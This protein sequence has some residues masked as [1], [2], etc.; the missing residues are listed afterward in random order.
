MWVMSQQVPGLCASLSAFVVYKTF[1]RHNSESDTGS[2]EQARCGV[3][4][5]QCTKEIQ[6]TPGRQNKKPYF[7]CTMETEGVL[8]VFF[9]IWIKVQLTEE[10]S[11]SI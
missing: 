9:I 3:R 6:A 1:S 11:V 4:H 2:S 10:L 7:Q 8:G 5:W